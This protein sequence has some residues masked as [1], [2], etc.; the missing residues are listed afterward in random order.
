[1]SFLVPED[2]DHHVLRDPV[3]AVRGL[4]DPVVVVDAACLR[5]SVAKMAWMRRRHTS[6]VVSS[7]SATRCTN[8]SAEIGCAEGLTTISSLN[9]AGS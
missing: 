8:S 5:G 4:D 6:G 9:I 3:D 2:V 1:V 7:S